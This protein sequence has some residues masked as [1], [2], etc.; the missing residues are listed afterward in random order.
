[1]CKPRTIRPSPLGSMQAQQRF[2]ASAFA[3]LRIAVCFTSTCLAT[4]IETRIDHLKSAWAIHASVTPTQLNLQ[5]ETVSS[6]VTGTI[7]ALVSVRI[8]VSLCSASTCVS[9]NSSQNCLHGHQRASSE[10]QATRDGT[11]FRVAF[12]WQFA[13]K[14][15]EGKGNVLVLQ[16][17]TF[18]A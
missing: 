8:S 13:T 10:T 5:S 3:I 18:R 14:S 15:E 17:R 7:S 2:S 4:K 6:I 9:Q 11:N 1:M 16:A 12:S